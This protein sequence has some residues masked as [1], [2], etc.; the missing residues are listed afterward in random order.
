MHFNFNKITTRNWN[1]YCTFDSYSSA[2]IW[3]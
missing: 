2:V 1:L 3:Y